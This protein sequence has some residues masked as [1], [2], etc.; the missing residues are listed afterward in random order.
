MSLGDWTHAGWTCSCCG[1][2]SAE[3]TDACPSCGHVRIDP[4]AWQAGTTNKIAKGGAAA[5][6]KCSKASG[7]IHA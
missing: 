6:E 7:T 1:Y 3:F 5:N 2:H 4:S